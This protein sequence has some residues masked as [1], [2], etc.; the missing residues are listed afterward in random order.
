M[1]S[2]DPTALVAAADRSPARLSTPDQLAAAWLLGYTGATRA[3]YAA[4]LRE[5][6]AWLERAGAEPF[7]AQRLHVEAF[8]RELEVAGRSRATI[9]RKLSALGGFYAYAVDEGLIGRS[10]VVKVRR[11][12][13]ADD[14]PTLGLDRDELRALIDAARACGPRDLALAML[15]AF[16]GL[17]VSEALSADVSDLGQQRGH[18]TL[19]LTR[20]GGRREVAVLAPVVAEAV[21]AYLA[22]RADGPLFVTASGRRLDR[23]AALKVVRKLARRA[24]IAKRITPHSLRHTF[25]TLALDSGA[26]LRDVQDAAG[27]RSPVTTRRY[28]RGRAALDRHPAYRLAAHVA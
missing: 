17:R 7:A 14:S 1:T 12:R 20:K 2:Q 3:A 9:A 10:P 16:N 18:R 13:V 24:G 6:G 26:E 15:L 25:V 28:D 4:D 27:H 19:A 23:H 11:P 21:D 22:G 5:W 8:A